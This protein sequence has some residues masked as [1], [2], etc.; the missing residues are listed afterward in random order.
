[1]DINYYINDVLLVGANSPGVGKS[2]FSNLIQKTYAQHIIVALGDFV[3]AELSELFVSNN[4]NSFKS[5]MDLDIYLTLKNQFKDIVDLDLSSSQYVERMNNPVTKVPYRL[6]MQY[7]GTE[8]K[9]GEDPYYWCNKLYIYC[10][11]NNSQQ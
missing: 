3:K 7:Y 11:K 2:Y 8:I 4:F 1:M 10:K 5:L 9:R 6:L